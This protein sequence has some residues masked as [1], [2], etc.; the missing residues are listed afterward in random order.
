M[1]DLMNRL[2]RNCIKYLCLSVILSGL[3]FSHLSAK[4]ITDMYGNKVT[5]PNKITR[6]FSFNISV[7]YMVYAIAPELI[8]GLNGKV[9]DYQKPF[10]PESYRSLP[11]LGS[12]T[13]LTVNLESILKQNPDILLVW[14]DE[15][16][17]TK[18]VAASL[19]GMKIPVVA[20]DANG[21]SRYNDSL[22]FLGKLFNREKRAE[23]LTAYINKT[24]K[25]IKDITSR[26]PAGKLVTVY[27][28]RN[29]NGLLTACEGTLHS[30]VIPM[31]G[32]I[33]PVKCG[34]S[35]FG[36][37]TISMEQVIIM[38]PDVIVTLDSSFAKNVYKDKVW[39]D[40]KAVKARRVYLT[41]KGPVNW[42]DMP[43]SMMGIL[44]MQWL[45]SEIYPDY[46]KKDIIKEAQYFIKL[47]FGADISKEEFIKI[48]EGNNIK[49]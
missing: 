20:I 15:G 27:N 32:G 10:F 47:F 6:V 14:G 13:S 3:F 21:L 17:Y 8:I 30:E 4:E 7:S 31:A 33:N 24:F 46:Y 19:S 26:I 37:E 44:G 1:D 48:V 34:A 45:T 23:E 9:Q 39:Q 49:D 22:H 40:I 12:L 2:I 36:V 25:D 5:V 35:E 16:A 43:P 38:N 29:R 28:V 41:P 11:V 42:F 18:K